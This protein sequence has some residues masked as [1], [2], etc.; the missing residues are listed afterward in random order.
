MVSDRFIPIA[1]SRSTALRQ[2]LSRALAFCRWEYSIDCDARLAS[3]RA[4]RWPNQRPCTNAAVAVRTW[5]M[6]RLGF[7]PPELPANVRQ[8][9]VAH[10]ADGQVPLQPQVASTFPVVKAQLRL[11]VLERALHAP[12]RE[13]DQQQG[14]RGGFGRRVAQE[15]FDL[16]PMQHIAG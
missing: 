16:L 4:A 3:L 12:P 9:Q 14:L 15:V 8:H 2:W 6:V 10:R 7:F 1:L 5:Q 11:A 13:P